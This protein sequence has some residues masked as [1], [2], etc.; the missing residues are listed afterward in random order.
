MLK[1]QRFAVR[2]A[3]LSVV[4]SILG[5]CGGGGTSSNQGNQSQSAPTGNG[6]YLISWD[7]ATDPRV[8]GYKLYYATA[9]FSTA[10]TVQTVSLGLDNTFTFSAAAYGI[11]SGT[12]LYVGI[13]AMGS[14]SESA[15]SDQVSIV[16][17]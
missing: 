11:S 7:S 15:L 4:V 14:G 3:L 13:A 10:A 12:T 6:T 1:Q 9:P 8:T 17:N 16:V 5:A 2:A